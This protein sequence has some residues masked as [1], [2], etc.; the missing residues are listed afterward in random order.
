MP[1]I[2]FLCKKLM[3]IR[4]ASVALRS[5][6]ANDEWPQRE[7]VDG[8]DSDDKPEPPSDSSGPAGARGPT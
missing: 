3:S 8:S 4:L 7:E 6:F 5:A 1:K 2:A